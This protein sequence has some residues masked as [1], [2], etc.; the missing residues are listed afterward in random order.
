MTAGASLTE[1]VSVLAREVKQA[2][3]LKTVVLL[4]AQTS[5][6]AGDGSGEVT[7]LDAR[8]SGAIEDSADFLLGCWRPELKKHIKT[9]EYAQCRGDLCFSILK[10]RRGLRDRFTVHFDTKTLRIS[11]GAAGA[12]KG[13]AA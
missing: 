5:R 7:V 8:D 10:N 12:S 6:S 9:D 4:I 11:A 2:E 3:E 13:E 1:R